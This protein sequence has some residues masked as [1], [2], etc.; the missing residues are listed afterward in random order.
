M[1]G[2]TPVPW[3]LQGLAVTVPVCVTAEGRHLRKHPWGCHPGVVTG[4]GD[5]VLL[6][7]G[8]LSTSEV[9]WVPTHA[10]TTHQRPR[11]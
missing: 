6:D 2:Q 3:W 9:C 7:A 11:G 5:T 8:V 4:A 1:H 10:E